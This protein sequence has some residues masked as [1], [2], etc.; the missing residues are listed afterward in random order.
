MWN[1][2][3]LDVKSES[4]NMATAE[5]SIEEQIEERILLYEEYIVE[6]VLASEILGLLDFI[7]KAK[8]QELRQLQKQKGEIKAMENLL[9]V[10]KETH[11]PENNK[12][13][14]F[15]NSLDAADYEYLAKTLRGF[16]TDRS[17]FSDS[18][19][20]RRLIELL[21]PE[22]KKELDPVNLIQSLHCY[23]VINKMDMEEI[24]AERYS[25]GN[26]AASVVLLDRVHRRH[27]DWFYLF[28]QA[29]HDAEEGKQD[30]LINSLDSLF[31]E[32]YEA[33]KRDDPSIQKYKPVRK[34]Q[35]PSF[36]QDT[37]ENYASGCGSA[38]TSENYA[39]PPQNS[40]P[41]SMDI[42]DKPS[43]GNFA[44]SPSM[45]SALSAQEHMLSDILNSRIN[46]EEQEEETSVKQVEANLRGNRS[47][48]NVP[49]SRLLAGLD[50]SNIKVPQKQAFP[51]SSNSNISSMSSLSHKTL[52][53][54][55][56]FVQDRI[57]PNTRN[58]RGSDLEN[59]LNEA[60]ENMER[61]LGL[62]EDMNIPGN[63]NDAESYVDNCDA[64]MDRETDDSVPR[65]GLKLR[66]YQME[67][68][69]SG[70]KGR[71]CIIVA[72]TGSGKTHVALKIIEEHFKRMRGRRN[73][74]VVFLVEQS[75]LAEQQGQQCRQYLSQEVKVITGETQRTENFQ[76]LLQWIHKRD[77]LVVTA[78][79]L[80][81]ALLEKNVNITQFS[82][83][84]FDECHHSNL[85]HSFNR[86]MHHYI[87]L[88]LDDA[89]DNNTLPQVVGLTASVGVGKAKKKE[90]AI[91]WIEKIMAHLD[92]HE[93]CTVQHHTSKLREYVSLP[94]QSTERVQGRTSNIFGKA[95]NNLMAKI[96][97]YIQK[98]KH[99]VAV[100]D[101]A[102]LRAPAKRGADPYTQWLSRLWKETAKV[103]DQDARRFFT[104]CRNYLDLYNKSLIIYEDARVKDALDF[105]DGSIRTINEQIIKDG[106]DRK[107]EQ[108]YNG[109]RS[110]LENCL[111]NAEQFN[112]KLEKL[113][114]MLVE[115]YRKKEDS[116][117]IIFV[118]TRDLVKA[119]ESWM[120]DDRDLKRLNPVKFVGAQASIEKGGMTKNEQVDVLQFFRSGQHKVIIA[121]S[122]AEEGLDIQ[123]CNLVIRY[124]YV[125][126][127]IA[128]VQSRGRGR[129]EDSKYV[130]LASEGG[131]AAQK[132]EINLMREAMMQNAIEKLQE[133]IQLNRGGFQQRILKI[134][135]EEKLARDMEATKRKKG[136][137]EE[138]QFELRCGKCQDYICM[139]SDVKTIMSAHHAV[140]CDDITDR[141][142]AKRLNRSQY[143]DQ[144][145]QS[146]VGKITCRKCGSDLGNV[147]IYNG[148]QFPIIKISSFSIVDAYGMADSK[149]KWK[150][151]PFNVSE[152]SV[153]DLHTL[154]GRRN[155]INLLP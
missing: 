120:K 143:S 28:L 40:L 111:Y 113:K 31:L 57:L 47:Q 128:M 70:L 7:D 2:Q 104:T 18:T 1:F 29:I 133:R 129:A 64:T 66:N 12:W 122:V 108:I 78:Q 83:L 74:K 153:E 35:P 33:K 96:E 51:S 25:R 69:D 72:P 36:D 62:R 87:D 50:F 86:I 38:F 130:L 60:N 142:A 94:E 77:I 37:M 119:I 20:H 146:G 10:I 76:E 3:L 152:L 23:K 103:Y 16:E 54:A 106:T 88:K 141:V 149:K 11:V 21:G 127:E 32:K 46:T 115:A 131:R 43:L 85:K 102:I 80:V 73:P 95:I 8:K 41:Y 55:P 151:V 136:A 114:E 117:G 6:C 44:D 53:S 140:I 147:S 137:I 135:M 34:S 19:N 9:D 124:D 150:Q 112:P 45:S 101:V 110:L 123:K 93:L 138:G 15:V 125:T 118:K 81:N 132:E 91:T 100:P 134:Q 84:V 68:A 144:Q 5:M 98:C 126:N 75:A 30:D 13:S 61:D 58:I 67:L 48:G 109:S 148:I 14:Q 49:M 27:K 65:E 105:L 97:E 56:T 107:M 92:A 22:I 82:L 4:R 59:Q 99:A 42:P 121:T 139:S 52:T 79:L 71:N 89:T 116:R 17:A 90:D 24:S 155:Q 145:L 63:T 39:P 26:M 154:L